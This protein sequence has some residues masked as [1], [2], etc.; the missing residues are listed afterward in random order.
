[1][2]SESDAPRPDVPTPGNAFPKPGPPRVPAPGT[3]SDGAAPDGA[4]P[5]GEAEAQVADVLTQLDGLDDR[6]VTE[7]VAAY[8]AVHRTL[9]DTLSAVDGS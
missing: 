8:E 4:A 7:H 1:M 6:P 3:G 2:T 5:D 9:Q